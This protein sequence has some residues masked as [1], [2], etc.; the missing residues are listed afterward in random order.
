MLDVVKTLAYAAYFWSTSPGLY[1]QVMNNVASKCAHTI[2]HECRPYQML[3]I[4][5]RRRLLDAHS[6]RVILHAYVRCQL[7]VICR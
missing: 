3:P 6:I 4:V 2:A 5:G 1:M 7:I